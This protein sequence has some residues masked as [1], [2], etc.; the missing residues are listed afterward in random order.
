MVS[1]L[2]CGQERD[3]MHGSSE[4]SDSAVLYGIFGV[5][6]LAGREVILK[7]QLTTAP[8]DKSAHTGRAPVNQCIVGNVV[9]YHRTSPDESVLSDCTSAD[10]GSVSANTG[11]FSNDSLLKLTFALDKS[12]RIDYICKYTGWPE[13]NIIFAEHARIQRYIVFNFSHSSLDMMWWFE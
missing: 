11:T 2:D 4:C 7:F 5:A 3:T 9:G 12:P 8:A 13:K 10:N 1:N 6:D